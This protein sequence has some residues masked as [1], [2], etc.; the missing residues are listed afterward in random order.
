[1]ERKKITFT[2]AEDAIVGSASIFLNG[3][4]VEKVVRGDTISVDIAEV[5]TKVEIVCPLTARYQ[6]DLSRLMDGDHYEIMYK[7][8]RAIRP[9]SIMGGGAVIVLFLFSEV[10]EFKGSVLYWLIVLLVPA[11]VIVSHYLFL[12]SRTLWVEKLRWD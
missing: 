1:M 6:M 8:N 2:L 4:I 9:L 5:V 11:L 10:P 12:R 3:K 7:Q